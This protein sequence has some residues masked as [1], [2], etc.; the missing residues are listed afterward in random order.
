MQS[1]GHIGHK[2]IFSAH[3]WAFQNR[4][5]IPPAL[6]SNNTGDV[7]E[8][9]ALR[10]TIAL[11]KPLNHF[12]GNLVLQ[13]GGTWEGLRYFPGFFSPSINKTS[14]YLLQVQSSQGLI[15]HFRKWCSPKA[16]IR[17]LLQNAQSGG[18][19]EQA[20]RLLGSGHFAIERN[21]N[22]KS[23]MEILI[24]QDFTDSDMYLP[25]GRLG[26]S[27]DIWS[28]RLKVFGN[29]NRMMRIPSLSDL[30]WQP[31]GNTDLDP[32]QSLGLEMGMRLGPYFVDRKWQGQLAFFRNHVKD[33]ILWTPNSSGLWFASNVRTVISQGLEL[34]QAFRMQFG[35]H[36]LS[37]LVNYAFVDSR[38]DQGYQLIYTPKHTA[39][40]RLDWHWKGFS[41]QLQHNWNSR[42]FTT[43]DNSEWLPGFG[44]TDLSLGFQLARKAHLLDFQ[45]G[46]RNLSNVE[47]QMVAQRPMPG[48]SGFVRLDWKFNKIKPW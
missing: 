30:Y 24:R 34:Q 21:W 48:R 5:E 45:I 26:A 47:Y 19:L 8:D 36:K 15:Y 12:W 1:I 9:E 4:R 20:K 10:A 39:F 11:Q 42:R 31:G 37:M 14:Q 17:L 44:T 3:I 16:G 41:A 46:I 2:S 27:K 25:Q 6:L 22:R 29:L 7:Q 40:G 32:E 28:S 35:Q 13:A 38:D 33:W 43:A 18:N 23:A